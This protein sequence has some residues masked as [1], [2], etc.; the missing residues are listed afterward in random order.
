M[1]REHTERRSKSGRRAFHPN[2]QGAESAPERREAPGGGHADAL[3]QLQREFEEQSAWGQQTARALAERD[4]TIRHLQRQVEEQSAWAR[5]S[6]EFVDE[7]D[8]TIGRLQAELEEQSAWARR[9][10]DELATSAAMV[11]GLQ[12]EAAKHSLDLKKVRA[13]IDLMA[14]RGDELAAMLFAARD[15]LPATQAHHSDGRP[16]PGTSLLSLSSTNGVNGHA[17]DNGNGSAAR[18]DDATHRTSYRSLVLKIRETVRKLLPSDAI[19]L[20]VSKGD[21]ELLD[22]PV[23][24]AWHFPRDTKGGYTGYYPADSSAAINHVEQLRHLGAQVPGLPGNGHLVAGLLRRVT[25]LPGPALP[26]DGRQRAL[27]SLRP[28]VEEPAR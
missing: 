19:V 21:E 7:R 16:K 20:V 5:R 8:C 4:E 2:G 10:A 3:A 27:P 13:Q 28:V 11:H 9:L 14:R 1:G 23:R 24:A 22:L 15:Q 25:A 6:S 17:A 12:A 26:P 18:L